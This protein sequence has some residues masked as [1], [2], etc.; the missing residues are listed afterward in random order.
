MHFY[1]KGGL[2]GVGFLDKVTFSFND[3]VGWFSIYEIYM[4][5]GTEWQTTFFRVFM[6]SQFFT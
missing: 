6:E 1:L 3:I 4:K 5:I 2:F